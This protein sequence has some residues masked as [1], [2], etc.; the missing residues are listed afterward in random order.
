MELEYDDDIYPVDDCE[1]DDA[2]LDIFY[3]KLF[4]NAT[5]YGCQKVT[6]E[7]RRCIYSGLWDIIKKIRS[8]IDDPREKAFKEELT[9]YFESDYYEWLEEKKS[10]EYKQCREF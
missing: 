9:D 7:Q 4:E 2:L 10:I 3:N 5:K 6:R 8:E 1:V